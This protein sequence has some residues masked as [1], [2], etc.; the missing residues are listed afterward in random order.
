M[1]TCG[2][3]LQDRPIYYNLLLKF[4]A[5]SAGGY[6]QLLGK[7]LAELVNAVF[8]TFGLVARTAEQVSFEPLMEL[9]IDEATGDLLDQSGA[10]EGE[11]DSVVR[12]FVGVL[13]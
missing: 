10:S 11:A 7:P 5:R 9:G 12:I 6:T 1:N 4:V 3:L 8:N 13:E 2:A